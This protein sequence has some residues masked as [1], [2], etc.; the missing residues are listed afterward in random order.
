MAPRKGA[1]SS[2]KL[3]SHES[4]CYCINVEIRE[5]H[6]CVLPMTG[7]CS[8]TPT[9]YLGSRMGLTLSGGEKIPWKRQCVMVLIT[10]VQC[11]VA[12]WS[13]SGYTGEL[14]FLLGK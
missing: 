11:Y 14:V 5:D 13:P 12:V 7:L 1:M 6:T 8:V 4:R 9:L 3:A 2:H 10:T